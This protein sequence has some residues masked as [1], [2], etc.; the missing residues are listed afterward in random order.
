MV[1]YYQDLRKLVNEMSLFAR[2]SQ[3]V[4]KTGANLYSKNLVAGLLV[5]EGTENERDYL[6]HQGS[7]EELYLIK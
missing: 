5:E 3:E 6:L 2:A 7:D 1:N 4:L